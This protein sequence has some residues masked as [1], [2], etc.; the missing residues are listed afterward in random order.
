MFFFITFNSFI[1]NTTNTILEIKAIA[2]NIL[3][4]AKI[5]LNNSK[6]NKIRKVIEIYVSTLLVMFF[7]FCSLPIWN[8]LAAPYNTITRNNINA[9]I[10][11]TKIRYT[12]IIP[13]SV[14]SA[15]PP[16]NI[17][18]HPPPGLSLSI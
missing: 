11:I 8:N 14:K 17:K 12:N 3:F 16:A 18:Y 10:A 9:G 7:H 5:I 6:H 4:K 1:N 2:N 13:K 15:V